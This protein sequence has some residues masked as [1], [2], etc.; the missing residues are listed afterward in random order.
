MLRIPDRDLPKPAAA[1][2]LEYQREVD[3][4]VAYA[5]RVSEAKRSF[6]SRNRKSNSTF[7]AVR[8]TLQT[9]CG[10]TGRCMYCEDSMADEIEHFKPKDLYPEAVFLWPNLLYACGPCNGSKRHRFLIFSTS[11]DKPLDITRAS[12]AEVLPPVAGVPVLINPRED[13]P[14]DLLALDLHDTFRFLPRARR[15]TRE[16][17]RARLTIEVLNLNRRDIVLE[18]RRV[19]FESLMGLLDRYAHEK[20]AGGSA[21]TLDGIK[22]GV[23]SCPHPT[24]WAEMKRQRQ[25]FLRIDQLFN[26]SPEALDW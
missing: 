11:G 3:A 7:R 18:A 9:M 19:A 26:R 1:R 10:A 13:Y 12:G 17:D 25:R 5:E 2:L 15:G 23:L 14:L 22:T 8:E 16:H 6:A 24:V 21:A 4:V 20:D